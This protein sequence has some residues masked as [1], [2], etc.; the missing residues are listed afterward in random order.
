MRRDEKRRK[1]HESLLNTLY[2]PPPSIAHDHIETPAPTTT[3]DV[4]LIPDDYGLHAT[5]DHDDG[6]SE[7]GEHK[8]TRAQR[9]RLR[10]KKLNEDT[11]RRKQLIGPLKPDSEGG[12]TR[13]ECT[14]QV[15][16]NADDDSC[17]KSKLKQR[18]MSKKLRKQS[19]KPSPSEIKDSL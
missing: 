10:N 4:N 18:R 15:R 5:S 2:P 16:Q 14:P 11:S 3:F 13:E 1:L 19:L 9:K 7:C 12:S 17:G 8:L 6:E